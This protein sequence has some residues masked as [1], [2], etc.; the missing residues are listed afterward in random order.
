MHMSGFA[1]APADC[2]ILLFQEWKLD[3]APKFALAALGTV[4]LAVVGEGLTWFRRKRMS[5]AAA[6][7]RAGRLGELVRWLRHGPTRWRVAMASLFAVQAALGYALMLIAMTYQAR[8]AVRVGGVAPG[9]GS[10][11]CACHG[12][13]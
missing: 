11:P 8:A 2:I 5:G 3:S 13:G 4:A 1:F 9:L 12:Y 7:A 6:L 10:R